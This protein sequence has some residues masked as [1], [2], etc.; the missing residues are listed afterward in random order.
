[1]PNSGADGL[2]GKDTGHELSESAANT[3]F[4]VRR[5]PPSIVERPGSRVLPETTQNG[6]LIA[7]LVFGREL[8]YLRSRVQ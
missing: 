1:M 4:L 6:G 5:C 8:G 2:F 7:M 3:Q